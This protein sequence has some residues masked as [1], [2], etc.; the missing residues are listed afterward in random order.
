MKPQNPLIGYWPKEIPTYLSNSARYRPFFRAA[1]FMLAS[2]SLITPMTYA[3]NSKQDDFEP[4]FKG[5]VSV[6]IGAGKSEPSHASVGDDNKEIDSVSAEHKK[7]NTAMFGIVGDLTYTFDNRQ[8]Q[9]FLT[10]PEIPAVFGDSLVELGVRQ[11]LKN[12]TQLS[13]SY[14]PFISGVGKEV[15]ED[16]YLTGSDRKETDQEINAFK[17]AAENILKLPVAIEYT[18]GTVDIE[19]EH[20]GASLIG[21]PGGISADEAKLLRRSGDFYRV[22]LGST[23]PLSESVFLSPQIGYTS[24]DADGQAQSF[25]GYGGGLELTYMFGKYVLTTGLAYESYQ[26]DASHPVFAKTREEDLISAN[27][28]LTVKEPFAWKN[29]HMSWFTSYSNED[30]NIDFYDSE[31]ASIG[32]LMGYSF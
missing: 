5:T 14:I 21:Q 11:R 23:L 30:S 3:A 7:E 28:S 10:S 12:E 16:P 22:A 18:F 31:E 15:W 4:G 2:M 19:N 17:F 6:I 29:T 26:Y 9:L 25:G 13:F 20:S 27:I 8:T 24:L 1:P 32:V